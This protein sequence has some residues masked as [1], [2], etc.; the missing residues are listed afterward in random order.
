MF[1]DQTSADGVIGFIESLAYI[2]D[3]LSF[4]QDQ[5]AAEGFLAT[6]YDDERDVL[7]I[8]MRTDARPI[9]CVVIDDCRAFVVSLGADAGDASVSFGDGSEGRRPPSGFENVTA[10]YRHGD[11]DGGNIAVS[12]L[13][14]GGAFAVLAF[15][16]DSWSFV[17][18]GGE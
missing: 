8:D 12:G 11:G 17:R 5:V 3:V 10:K 7:Q 13:G 2:G 1:G 15:R 16:R 9:V 6:R 4:A 14:L 18:C